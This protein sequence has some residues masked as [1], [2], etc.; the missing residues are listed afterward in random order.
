MYTVYRR[1]YVRGSGTEE[2]GMRRDELVSVGDLLFC[3]D[4]SFP[5][6]AIGSPATQLPSRSFLDRIRIDTVCKSPENDVLQND[7][8]IPPLF[9]CVFARPAAIDRDLKERWNEIKF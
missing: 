1:A 6:L 4:R 7:L 5:P 8:R 2:K 9:R 3:P